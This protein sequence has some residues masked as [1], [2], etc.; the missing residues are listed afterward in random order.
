MPEAERVES[1]DAEEADD[2]SLDPPGPLGP[3]PLHAPIYI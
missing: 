3:V 1:V 2:N